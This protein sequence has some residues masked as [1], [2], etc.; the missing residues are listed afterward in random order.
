[1]YDQLNRTLA[2][3]SRQNPRILNLATH[4][5]TYMMQDRAYLNDPYLYN[6]LWMTN[7]LSPK[8]IVDTITSGY[9]DI[10]IATKQQIRR[11]RSFENL[12]QAAILKNY[13][14]LGVEPTSG[15]VIFARLLDIPLTFLNIHPP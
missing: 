13:R 12:L 4:Q 8:P 10:I 15:Y 5:D 2:A 11:P 7:V 1:M 6:I 3:G 14:P 9:F